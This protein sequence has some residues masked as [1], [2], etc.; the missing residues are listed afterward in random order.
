MKAGS[1]DDGMPADY[2]FLCESPVFNVDIPFYDSLGVLFST[3]SPHHDASFTRLVEKREQWHCCTV[4]KGG[5][6]EVRDE[7]EVRQ[8]KIQRKTPVVQK[9]GEWLGFELYDCNW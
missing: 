5:V 2:Q 7:K 3:H 4:G 8:L 6:R 9:V 1:V